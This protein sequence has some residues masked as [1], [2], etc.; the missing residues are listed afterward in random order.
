MQRL[1]EYGKSSQLDCRAQPAMLG[2]S[3]EI[4]AKESRMAA[5]RARLGNEAL[6][7][8][9]RRVECPDARDMSFPLP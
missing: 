4:P 7:H 9:T 5:R 3:R 8:F 6:Q 1:R 2:F